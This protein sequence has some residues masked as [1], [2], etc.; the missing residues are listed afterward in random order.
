MNDIDF[1]IDIDFGI[2]MTDMFDMID[3]SDINHDLI[4]SDIDNSCD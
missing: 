2:D 4:D 1:N 3:T